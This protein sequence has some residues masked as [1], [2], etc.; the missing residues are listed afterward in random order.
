M[1]EDV[2]RFFGALLNFIHTDFNHP[3]SHAQSN[4]NDTEIISLS[5]KRKRVT[6]FQTLYYV[7]HNGHKRAPMHIKNAQ[8]IPYM[9]YAKASLL[10]KVL[11]ILVYV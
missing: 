1:P 9:R 6:L 8:A 2:L 5:R 7:I 4:D 11:I 3:G 10:S